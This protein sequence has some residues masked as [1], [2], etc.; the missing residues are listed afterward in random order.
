[1]IAYSDSLHIL[2]LEAIEGRRIADLQGKELEQ[3]LRYMGRALAAFH[4]IPAGKNLP[5]FTRLDAEQLQ[6]AAAAISLVRPDVAALAQQLCSS[7]CADGDAASSEKVRAHGDIHPKNGI[8]RGD[9]VVLIDLDQT[10]L[11]PAAADL[12]SL[13]AALRY[14]VITGSLTAEEEGRLADAFL[15]GY[16][17]VRKLPRLAEL[18]WHMAA[19]LLAERALRSVSRVRIEGLEHLRELLLEAIGLRDEIHA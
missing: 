3:G 13:L 6:Q 10:G 1:V 17:S 18:R 2:I 8:L 4:S 9:R 19:A 12:G 5:K 14:D 11:A 7:L 15:S 16:S